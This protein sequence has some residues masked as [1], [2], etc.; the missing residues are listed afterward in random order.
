MI[1]PHGPAVFDT[2]AA[3]PTTASE[4]KTSMLIDEARQQFQEERIHHWD[5]VADQKYRPERPS[6]CYHS[7]LKHYYRFL[8]P[9]GLKVLEL[10]CGRGDL[11]AS[12]EPSF[13]VGLDF[14][15]NMLAK[16]RRRHPDLQF[17]RADAHQP[18][19]RATFDVIVLSDLVNDVWD[20]QHIF[21][22]LKPMCHPGTRVILNFFNEVWRPALRFAHRKGWGVDVKEQSWLSH[23]D[24][25]NLIE[26]TDFEVINRSMRILFPI[27]WPFIAPLLNRYLVNL[28]PFSML[29]LT[30]FIT[31][32][33]V[34]A[35]RDT[36][37]PRDKS[38]SVIVP[39]RNE[40]GNISN[41]IERTPLLGR[42]TE[43]VFVEGGSQ[44]DTLQTI[45]ELIPQ[46]PEKTIRLYQQKG[47]GKGDAVRLG[48]TEARGDIL[49]IL[50]ADLTVSPA[51]LPRFYE[52]IC[53]RKGEFINGVR[54]VYP[55]ENQ[56]MRFFNKLGNKFF[57]LAFSW[58]LGQPVKDT[59]C[60]TKVLHRSDYQ[61]IERNRSYFG[62]F[63]P[64]G[65]FDLLFGAAKLNLKIVDMPIRYRARQYG[66]TNIS[67]W[68][69][70]L[71]LLRM[72]VFAARRIRF[73]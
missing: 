36:P 6:R 70:G 66:Q 51:D 58:L 31:A 44:D 1:A 13:G 49:M 38:V 7:L 33:P 43:L 52:A 45:R 61:L 17:M 41:I 4:G 39:A 11:L 67:R 55:M 8:I 73:I 56:S 23:N 15:A 2:A 54:L 71:L 29:A 68:K 20:V 62:D 40:A 22:Q 63:D 21:A 37:L 57:S 10:G 47:H 9:P 60:G 59:L 3:R 18:P 48:F 19:I 5:A 69:H 30:I 28:F 34:P 27:E 64:F 16:A 26:L 53:N 25:I 32:R 42:E 35:V 72:V 50:D 14:S 46:H 65:D 24:V 12:L